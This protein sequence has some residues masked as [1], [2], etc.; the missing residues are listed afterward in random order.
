MAS[1]LEY[2]KEERLKARLNRRDP[3]AFLEAHAWLA[4]KLYRHALLRLREKEAAEDVVQTAFL[5]AWEYLG[6]PEIKL[7]YVKAFFYRIV[8]NLIVDAIRGAVR[9]RR[10]E[11]PV[12][13]LPVLTD[14]AS[15]A[16]EEQ[17]DL[18]QVLDELGAVKP[19]E[20]DILMW[21]YL[22]GLSIKE[23]SFLTEKTPNH[24]A[25]LIHRTLKALRE[26]RTSA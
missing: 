6:D 13:T 4:P 8:N 14:S 5:N 12:E 22:D 23:I 16:V 25:V 17:F 10:A 7:T 15:R 3:E 1:P 21:R 18:E 24:I 26:K 2:L 9:E 11:E 20:R 19:F